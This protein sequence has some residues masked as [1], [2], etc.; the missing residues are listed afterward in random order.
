MKRICTLILAAGLVFGAATGASAVDFKAKGAWLMG[1]GVGTDSFVS[2]VSDSGVKRKA[3]N[4]DTFSARQRVR[5]QLDAVASEALSGTVYFEIGTQN[6]GQNAVGNGFQ[7]GAALGADGQGVR[8]KNAYLDWAIPQTDAK[9]RMAVRV[10]RT[11][12]ALM[13]L[14]RIALSPRRSRA[15]RGRPAPP[16]LWVYRG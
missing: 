15:T 4:N 9:V 14:E 6:W 16:M 2:K 13:S 7:G 1:F 11:V 12:F 8:V 3:D 10:T 5:L